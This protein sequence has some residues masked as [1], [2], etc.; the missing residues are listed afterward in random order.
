MRKSVPVFVPAILSVSVIVL[1]T[2][3][4]FAQQPT[5]R[6]A[7]ASESAKKNPYAG[8]ASAAAAGKVL[9]GKNCSQCHG[10]NR[11]GMGPAPALDTQQVQTAKPG[12]LFWFIE[13]GKPSSGMP[14]WP[15]LTKQQKWQVVTFL[16]TKG[17]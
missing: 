2:L 13:V 3:S 16:E 17:K 1:L 5:F 14:A 4:A 7:P 6:N 9:Y 10:N 12:E 8:S 11:Q 15:T